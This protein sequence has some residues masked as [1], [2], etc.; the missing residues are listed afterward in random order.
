MNASGVPMLADFGQSRAL[1]YTQQVLV[2]TSH[3]TLKGTAHWIAYELLDFLDEDSAE[4]ACTKESD[5]WAYGMVVYV[6]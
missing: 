2:T 6:I 1:N 4:I 5:M 3:E